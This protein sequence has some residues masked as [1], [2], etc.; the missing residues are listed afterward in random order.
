MLRKIVCFAVFV[1]AFPCRAVWAAP[2]TGVVRQADG[3]VVRMQP[4]VLRLVVMQESVIRVTYAAGATIPELHSSSVVMKPKV[5]V[6]WTLAQTRDAVTLATAAVRVRVDRRTGAVEFLDVAGKTILT[7]SADGREISPAIQPGVEGTLVRQAFVL[8]PDE[9]I[10]GLGQHQQGVWNYRG[11]SVQLLQANREVGIPVLLS[12][13][14]YALLWDNPAVTTVDVGVAGAENAVR[15]TSEV[16]DAIDYYFVAG[17]DPVGAMRHYRELTGE[18]PLMPE[19]LL[20]FWQSKE[21]YRTQ[22]EV[23]GIAKR[24]RD[25]QVP[26]DGIVQD[27]RYWPDN[28]WGSNQFDPARYPDPAAMM[29]QLHEMHYHVVISVWPKFDLGTAN[30]KELEDAGAMY[31]PVIPYVFPPG[32]GKWYDAFSATGR[33]IYWK[34]ISTQIFTKGFDG[35]WLDA[36]E[37]ELSGKW[38]EFRGFQTAAGPGARVFN[39]YPLMHSTG[40]Y[41]GQRALTDKQRVVVLTRSAFAGQQ[42]NSAVTWSGDIGANWKVFQAQVPAGL[43]FSMSGIPYWNTDIGGFAGIGNPSDPKYA[44]IF[45]RW[46]EYGS[47]CPMF[48]VHGSAPQGGTGIGK[49]YWRFDATTQAIWRRYD[50]LRYR[51]MPYLYSVTWQVTHNGASILRPLMMDYSADKQAL[52]VGDQY[53]YGPSIMVSP[54]TTQGA[55]TRTVYLPGKA[56]WYDFWTGETEAGGRA[57]DA[58]AA[59]DTMPLYV[60][61]GAVLPMG[62]KILYVGEKPAD[63]MELRVYR[64]ANGTFDLY[65]DEGDTYDYEKGVYAVIPIRWNEATRT[66]TIGGRK[67]SFPGMLKERTFDVVM[68]SAEHGAGVEATAKA[69]RVVRYAG[70]AVSVKFPG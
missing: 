35:W 55:R 20:G 22:D 8:A 61:A 34:Q 7:E 48:R 66:L 43:N 64:G 67:G 47:F 63:P 40:I 9:G 33:A 36:P 70:R 5:G 45:S 32:Q 69:D 10:Y 31:A 23:L 58:A 42:R 38:G 57:V 17:P 41:Q 1:G 46:F 52:K 28:T 44:E 26:I 21:R 29:T 2:V 24:Y 4:G 50:D 51:L 27:W 30:I 6:K 11:H 25:L 14:G 65:E 18:A 15:W 56:K 16:G 12:S 3:V 54:V 13:K 62:P 49:E 37:P 60:P 53:L 19:W 39:A 59:L 68:V